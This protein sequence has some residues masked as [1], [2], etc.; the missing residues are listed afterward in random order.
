VAKGL[1]I[2]CCQAQA[3]QKMEEIKEQELALN[4]ME[5]TRLFDDYLKYVNGVFWYPESN[6]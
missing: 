2:L 1:S 3:S 5:K 6:Y 4:A